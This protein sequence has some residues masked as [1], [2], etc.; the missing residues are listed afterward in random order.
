MPEMLTAQ[1]SRTPVVQRLQ[2]AIALLSVVL[3]AAKLGA[4]FLTHSVTVL[5]D[6]LESTVNVL[7]GFIGLYSVRVAAR[8]RDAD[9]PYGHAKAEF[10]S[11][12]FEGLLIFVAGLLILYSAAVQLLRP[13]HLER[14]D[15]GLWIVGISGAI[16]WVLGSYAVRIG[17]RDRSLTVESA[18]R[19]LRSDA[20]SSAGVLVGLGLLL[21]TGW[22]WLDAAVAAVFGVVILVTGYR[23]LRRSLAGI[24]DE[25]DLPLLQDVVRVLQENRKDSWIDLHNLRVMRYGD[26]LHLDAH[27]TLPWY[28]RVIDADAETHALEALMQKQFGGA[29]ELFVHIDGCQYYQCKLC[30]VKDCP[31]RAEPLRERLVWTLENVWEDSKHG[32]VS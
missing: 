1:T 5:T 23:V 16:N 32:K 11:A 9:H 3:F 6:A 4:W 2:R 30:A 26:V 19:H 12:A 7:A 13:S 18:G 25:V 10:V 17:Q 8:P 14:L 22:T 15:A 31:V 29:A 28:S 27:M 21:L 24:M 20:Y